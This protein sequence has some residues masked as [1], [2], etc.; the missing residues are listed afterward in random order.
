MSRSARTLAAVTALAA[1]LGACRSDRVTTTGSLY[2]MDYRTRHPIVLADG[3]R[4]LDVFAI[5]TGHLDPRQTADIDAF[6]LE[7]R[8][9]GRGTLILDLPRGVAP[10]LGAAVERTAAAIR[11]IA[12]E[13]GIPPGR[14]AVESY[15]VV[16]PSLSAPLRL[17]F[18]KMEAKVGSQ[19]GI[20]PQDLGVSD[21]SFN[22]RN[23][24]Y[25][26]LGCAMQANVATQIADPVDL[27]RGR[28]EG[29]IDTVRRTQDI[30]K[31]R[32]G[33]DPSIQWKQDGKTSVRSEVSN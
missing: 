17:S 21:P 16:N 23:E 10:G 26:N 22:N 15:A 25:W 9:Y 5:G 12:A 20:W 14:I 33:K 7:F 19:C 4:H 11:R 18:Q 2:P 30:G 24:P 6:I 3:A 32:E 29:R 27:V 1:L 31:V 28:P 8:R 13:G